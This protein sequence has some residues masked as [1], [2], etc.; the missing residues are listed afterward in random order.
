MKHYRRT[1][2]FTFLLSVIA[3]ATVFPQDSLTINTNEND[4]TVNQ[5]L[6]EGITAQDVLNNYIEAIGGREAYG[7]IKDKTTVMRGEVMNQNFS[8]VIKQK[9]P[10]KL[11]QDMRMGDVKQTILFDG[12]KAVQIV[13]DKKSEI[14]GGQLEMIKTEAEMGFILD[15]ESFGTTVSLAGI[16]KVD[17]IDCYKI[18]LTPAK[19]DKW[20]QYYAVDTG[21]KVKDE[22]IVE[23]PQ[24]KFLREIYYSDYRDVDGVKFPFKLKQ[25]IGM[26]TV[27][28]TVSSVKINKGLKDEIFEI[29]E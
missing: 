24:G 19:G 18:E 5:Q 27:E 15:P 17:S 8:I 10:N 7:N 1:A 22:K 25:S 21:L 4:K 13:G 26:Q 9:A 12:T 14:T 29:P 3:I 2:L 20:Y 11:K 23:F 28:L 16:E 6:P